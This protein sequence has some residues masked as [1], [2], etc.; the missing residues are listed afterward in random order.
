MVLRP[1]YAFALLLSKKE[2]VF[3]NAVPMLNLL[4]TMFALVYFRPF[5]PT[6][7]SEE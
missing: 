5:N 4:S 6:V 2:L 3:R 1:C 7:C